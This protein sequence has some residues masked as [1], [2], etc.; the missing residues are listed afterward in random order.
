M[1]RKIS[2]QA[3]GML[4]LAVILVWIF[5]EFVWQGRVSNVI[6]DFF[7][8]YFHMGYYR[9][10][11]VYTHIFRNNSILW[12]LIAIAGAFFTLFMVMLR[13]FTRYF[14]EINQ[15]ID[16][17]L[18]EGKEPIRLAPELSAVEQK[19]NTV[20]GTLRSRAEEI[21]K[22]QQRKNDLVM[23]LAHDIKT[24]LTSVIG[25]L[26]LL[27][28]TPEM[29]VELKAKYTH[30]TLEKAYRLEELVN[31]FFEITRYNLQTIELHKEQVDLY[32]LLVQLVDEFYPQA[33]SRKITVELDAEE[34][35]SVFGDPDKLARVFNNLLK[36]AIAYS[37][38]ATTIQIQGKQMENQVVVR[39]INHGQ[40]I[41]QEQ[42]NQIFGKFY[43]LDEARSTN[44]GGA[45]LGLSIAKEIITLHQGTI[46][47]QSQEGTT[48]F[49]V[50]LPTLGIS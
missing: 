47:V 31:E 28:E 20:H 40:T 39:I 26:S 34:T 3:V 49:T 48:E 1:R 5:Y 44:T 29:P 17:L 14:N 25:Y 12:L 21:T 45:G 23:Y 38:S 16:A 46:E 41:P 42:L 11:N 27:D 22:E 7:V 15:G 18:K 33:S 8:K 35:L 43:R 9:A 36:N 10:V 37:D 32:Y 30:I 50:Q 6:V 19:L 13:W 2:L 24:P 4:F